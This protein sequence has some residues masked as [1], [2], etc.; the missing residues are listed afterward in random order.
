MCNLISNSDKPFNPSF[1]L[2]FTELDVTFDI[3]LIEFMYLQKLMG[4]LITSAGADS[5]TDES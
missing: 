3:E 1:C 2:F 5:P 4:V